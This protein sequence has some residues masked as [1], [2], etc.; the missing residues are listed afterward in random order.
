MV[1]KRVEALQAKKVEALKS[2]RVESSNANRSKTPTKSGCSRHMTGVKSYPHKYMEQPGSKFDEKRGTI[3]NSN[4]EVVMIAPRVRDV[5]VLD[6]TSSTQE[7]CFFAKASENLNWLW[8][9]RLAHL[10]F[11]TINKMAKQNLVIGL[12]SLVYSKDKPCSS[13]EKGNHHRAN[14]KTKHTSSIK[15]YLHLL[16]MDL[17]GPV[18]PRKFDE[19][20]NDGYFLVYSPVSKALK[21]FNIR[22]QQTEETYHI[23]FDESP[24]AIKFIK[25]SVN[26][27]NIAESERH[28]PDEYLHPYE[29]FQRTN[30]L[31]WSK[32]LSAA[33][34]LECIFVDFLSEKE[35]KKVSE[36]LKHLLTSDLK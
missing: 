34:A 29:P 19:K 3:F 15:K 27:I 28:P 16:H 24:Y 18:T 35:P 21:V 6:M 25:P 23:T 1:Q 4:K 2:T 32:E 9:K 17:F 31:S 30:I 13:R 26:N 36:A 14:F 7:S 8:H 11:K 5:Y 12:P 20:A 33:S 10:N 22:R